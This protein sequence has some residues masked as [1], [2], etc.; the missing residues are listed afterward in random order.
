MVRGMKIAFQNGSAPASGM[1]PASDMVGQVL[2]MT[3]PIFLAA[4]GAGPFQVKLLG[5]LQVNVLDRLLVSL[6]LNGVLADSGLTQ[7]SFVG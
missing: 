7:T 3:W 2:K 6:E 4:A 5:A 1:G